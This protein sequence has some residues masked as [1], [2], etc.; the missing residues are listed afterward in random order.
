MTNITLYMPEETYK[1]MKKY[2]ELKWS[3]IIRES[4]ERK[5]KE[6]DEAEYRAYALKR[7]AKEGED[8][9]E[10]FKF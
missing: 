4:V 5:L 9:K 3:E 7:L 6:L 1:R 8:A 2:K 10:L